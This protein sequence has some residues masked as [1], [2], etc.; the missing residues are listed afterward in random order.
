MTKPLLPLHVRFPSEAEALRKHLQIAQQLTAG[1]RLRAVADL[2]AAATA[3]GKA[4]KVQSAQLRHQESLE[5]DWRRRMKEF[6]KK[7]AG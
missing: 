7:H 1:Q 2:V 4:G 5:E 3:L 6:I